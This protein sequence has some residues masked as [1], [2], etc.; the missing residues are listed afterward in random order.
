MKKI[1]IGL[2]LLT[3]KC[4]DVIH[5]LEIVTINTAFASRSLLYISRDY[6]GIVQL[7]LFFIRIY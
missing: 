7:E 3:I 5:A 1:D 2:E 4:N 6:Q